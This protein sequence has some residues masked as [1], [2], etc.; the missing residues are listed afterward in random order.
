MKVN[1][2][3]E[4]AF[5]TG[6]FQDKYD[7]MAQFSKEQVEKIFLDLASFRNWYLHTD[8]CLIKNQPITGLTLLEKAFKHKKVNNKVADDF[9]KFCW[10]QGHEF[11]QDKQH[12][13]GYLKTIPSAV[14]TYV[15]LVLEDMDHSAFFHH[16]SIIKQ[17]HF[18][19]GYEE[20]VLHKVKQSAFKSLRHCLM[21]VDALLNNSDKPEFISK[22]KVVLG[23]RIKVKPQQELEDWFRGQSL[24]NFYNKDAYNS[25][26][27]DVLALEIKKE[28]NRRKSQVEGLTKDNSL[29]L[30][31]I[32]KLTT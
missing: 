10:Q 26:L 15:K 32:K 16:A 12:L 5:L 3:V 18:I 21:K 28:L 1:P 6:N 20:L 19:L 14:K 31:T 17:H 2:E 13:M 8:G 4:I 11:R 23:E 30:K 22:L 9:V 27:Q 25:N 24:E 7:L 29:S